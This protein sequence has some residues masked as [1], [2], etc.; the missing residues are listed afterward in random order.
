MLKYG[1]ENFI[2]ELVERCGS[3]EELDRQEAYWIKRF[4]STNPL[5]GYN[6]SKGGRDADSKLPSRRDREAVEL[7]EVVNKQDPKKARILRLKDPAN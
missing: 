5:V 4:D 6:Q 1:S 2:V 7:R 3:Q